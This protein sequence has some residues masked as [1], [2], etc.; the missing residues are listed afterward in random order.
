MATFGE[1]LRKCRKEAGLTQQ[2]L[3]DRIGTTHN[4]VSLYERDKLNPKIET[5]MK[6]ADAL[7]VEMDALKRIKSGG[8]NKDGFCKVKVYN[9]PNDVEQYIVARLS[10]GELWYWGC[11]EDESEAI[12]VADEF[13]NGLVVMRNVQ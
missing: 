3:A 12:E 11:Y 9:C 8:R 13:E 5:A 2:Q 4:L 6:F 10:N 1:N 7:N